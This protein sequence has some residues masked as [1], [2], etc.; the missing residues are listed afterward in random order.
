VASTV[1]MPS[2]SEIYLYS[3]DE[4]LF[5]SH[6]F[7][8]L[9]N[10]AAYNS[11]ISS[12]MEYEE[13]QR[14]KAGALSAFTNDAAMAL[15]VANFED[16]IA[17]TDDPLVIADLVA[18]YGKDIYEQA[19]AYQIA[20]PSPLNLDDRPLYWARLHMRAALRN[21]PYFLGKKVRL[22]RQIDKLEVPSRGLFD[23]HFKPVIEITN[24]TGNDGTYRSYSVQLLSGNT[25]VSVDED[26]TDGTADGQIQYSHYVAII[27]VNEATDEFILSGNYSS[28]LLTGNPI[29]IAQTQQNNGHYTVNTATFGGTNTTVKINENITNGIVEGH[30]VFLRKKAIGSVSTFD[31]KITISGDIV[32]DL[33]ASTRKILVSGFDTFGLSSTPDQSNPAGIIGLT[34]HRKTIKDGVIFAHIQS[35]GIYP[36]CWRYFNDGF[37]EKGFKPYI[38]EKGACD[39]VFTFSQDGV[40]NSI[41]ID[42]F[43]AKARGTS[44]DN[45]NLAS[46]NFPILLNAKFHYQTTLPFVPMITK[47]AIGSSFYPMQMDQDFAPGNPAQQFITFTIDPNQDP[48]L[49]PD[50]ASPPTGK[51]TTGSG[52]NYMSNEIAYRVARLRANYSAELQTG[53]VHVMNSSFSFTNADDLVVDI[54]KGIKNMLLYLK[55]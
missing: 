37:I 49:N 52:S 38:K 6:D 10:V 35:A 44:T 14:L 40:F 9:E 19:L 27:G 5:T 4:L 12:G 45:E 53:H 13:E 7:G 3:R 47:H 33:N 39:A 2:G 18:T 15:L 36:V 20:H 26:L 24:S 48:S 42:R 51:L 55:K 32:D 28:E 41:Q 34:L 21:H 50:W 25:V 31:N 1:T 54:E 16:D 29:A 11:S 22:K 30:L 8:E 23:V 43:F 46:P 17:A